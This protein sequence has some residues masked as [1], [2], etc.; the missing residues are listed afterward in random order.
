[1]KPK[2]ANLLL[3]F[4]LSI[5]ATAAAQQPPTVWIP[6]APSQQPI[7]LEDV[8]IAI[9][10][11]GFLATT[12]IEMTFANPNPRVLEG[13]FVFPLGQGQTLSGYALEV[14]GKLREGVV[15]PKETARVAF[16]ETTRVQIDP[17]LAEL[18]RG[19]VFRT[20]LYPIPANGK[21]RIA[22]EFTQV[23]DDAGAHWRYLL[24]LHFSAPVKKFSVLA[25]APLDAKAPEL[26][27]DSPDATL[28][29]ESAESVWRAQ[30]T[31]E[32]ITPQKELSFRVPK[33][34]DPIAVLE[35]PDA[36][37][38]AQRAILAQIDTGR[39]ATLAAPAKPRRIA[40][41]FDASGSAGERDLVRE[42]D[43]LKAVFAA[44]DQVQVELTAFRDVAEKPR[45]FA[46]RNGDASKLLA[47]LEALPLDGASNYS[48]IDFSRAP[49]ADMALVIGD[50]LDTFGSGITDFS[51][52][53]ARIFVLHA[54]Q[55]ADHPRLAAIAGHGG[56]SVLDL[57]RMDAAHAV[58]TLTQARWQLLSIDSDGRCT[59]VSPVAKQ[60]VEAVMTLTA[61]CEGAATLRLRFGTVD[62]GN[63][64]ERSISVGKSD[65]VTGTLAQAVWRAFAQTRIA[66]LEA[67]P[68]PDVQAIDA[69]ALK[70]GV[71]TSRTSLLVLDRIEDYVRYGVEPAQA[72]LRAEYQR[73]RTARPKPQGDI[74]RDARI[75]DLARRWQEFR[76]WHGQRHP[77][78]E[79]LL[80]PAAA[81]ELALWQRIE[82]ESDEANRK[83]IAAARKQAEAIDAESRAL[84]GQW[85]K[86]GSEAASRTA[87]EKQA[88]ALMLQMDALRTQ[89]LERIP[90]S[91]SWQ[92][93]GNEAAHRS[94][95]MGMGEAM[96]APAAP[97]PHDAETAAMAVPPSPPALPAPAEESQSLDSVVVSG[98]RAQRKASPAATPAL[99][100]EISLT[101]W[102]PD[103]PYLKTLR[104]AS[105][106]YAAYLELRPEHADA[107]S[108]FLDAADYFREEA[109]QPELALRVLSNLAEI[110]FE[111]TALLRVLGY[112][113][114][115]W[116]LP[117]LA[118]RP[119]EDALAL[120]PEE[121]QSHRDLAL[122]LA[123]LPQPQTNRAI[124][125]LWF[126]A[127]HDW[128]GRFP[129]I[130]LI[131]LHEL[132]AIFASTKI[133][134]EIGTLGIPEAFLDPL[135][136]DLRVVLT[137]DADNT[138][139]DLW[140]I[141]PIGEAVYYS[142]P[143][144]KSGGHISRDFT[145]GYGP[146]AFTIARPLPGTYRIQAH[147]FGDRRQSLT[148][149]VTVQV[150]FSTGF[151]GENPKRIATTRRLETGKQRI[152]VGSFTVRP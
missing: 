72:D 92:G 34:A 69:L 118:I 42:R 81:H 141:D 12:R 77:W 97:V 79:T 83:A 11:R 32:N 8:D 82:R 151:G 145:G 63:S 41:F 19:N 150:E 140:V 50:G 24:P 28:R 131:A 136:T 76:D 90:E 30:F 4:G 44:L 111:N 60:T 37:E 75:A 33:E 91:E 36:L 87:W 16:E 15:V 20:R 49:G 40:L 43:A 132:N 133:T 126:V 31:R 89:R 57:S 66:Q 22:L 104:A 25:Q 67:A 21:K 135:K 129:D 112:R 101:G 29:F 146:E 134:P 98:A 7:A 115:Q 62:G 65:A 130:D 38:P 137:W 55:R 48:A 128:H 102:N 54:A 5:A 3:V 17:G 100:A 10:M 53:P 105:D 124:E 35:A 84:A 139:I 99:K 103:T 56:G 116:N 46:I 86:A 142:Q 2:L 23:M 73:L 71:V 61:R 52:A 144:S 9:D 6:P 1:M 148:G 13:E 80:A 113:L 51:K 39:P 95:S 138:D 119:F 64:V 107:P 68:A 88:T 117:T 127:T 125:R 123:R 78:L 110:G 14:N 74:G 122:A 114:S 70:H 152:D 18:T 109:R 27:A 108:F 143:R 96:P 45:T 59:E 94:A 120:R 47:A 26:A 149:P 93:D 58:T 106:A 121:P 85:L 147:Y